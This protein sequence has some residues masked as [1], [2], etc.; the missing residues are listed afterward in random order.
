MMDTMRDSESARALPNIVRPL[1]DLL[2]NGEPAFQKDTLEY[3]YRRI[4][5]EIFNRL[6]V[7]EAIRAHLSAIFS[8]LLH[9][10]RNDNEEIGQTAVKCMVDLIRNY[11][12]VTEELSTEF[13]AIFQEAHQNMKGLVEQYLAEDSP[14][15]DTNTAL[16]A[17]CSFKVLGE[18]GMVMVMMSQVQKNLVST[19]IQGS[20]SCALEVLA[21]ESSAQNKA[22]SDFEAMGGIWAGAADT[23]KNPGLYGDFIQAQIKVRILCMQSSCYL[24]YLFRCFLISP[25]S[26]G[27]LLILRN[28]MVKHSF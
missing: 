28:L 27:S 26:C 8:C 16:P 25:I 9:I 15:L 23:I 5:F 2:R 4:I 7:H 19:T 17:L 14:L 18:M 13:V 20:A 22:R 12:S 21:L 1:V 11:R 3:Q 10:I 24:S 6:P